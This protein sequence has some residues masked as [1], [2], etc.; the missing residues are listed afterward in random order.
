MSK[1]K[2]IAT[3][4]VSWPEG[5]DGGYVHRERGEDIGD[6]PSDVLSD[7]TSTKGDDGIHYAVSLDEWREIQAAEKA[8]MTLSE[9]RKAKKAEEKKDEA[10]TDDDGKGGDRGKDNGSGR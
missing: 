2:V 6:A 3:R 4:G 1:A 10:Q 5:E 9:Y 7:F 8:E